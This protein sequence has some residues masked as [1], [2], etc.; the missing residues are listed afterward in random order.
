MSS[1]T[2]SSKGSATPTSSSEGFTLVT[3]NLNL[4]GL[5]VTN[6]G[7]PLELKCV[8]VRIHKDD[9][10]DFLHQCWVD[11]QLY[12]KQGKCYF[13]WH[14]IGL[15]LGIFTF[16]GFVFVARSHLQPLEKVLLLHPLQK[17][18]TTSTTTT[19]SGDSVVV[20]RSL[21]NQVTEFLEEWK[22]HFVL[23]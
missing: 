1:A 17:V 9:M 21:N 10:A 4:H 3:T 23:H 20:S 13:Y 18:N 2:S 12:F 16:P 22:L 14:L 11:G 8:A 15:F 5:H 7:I 6:A 19:S